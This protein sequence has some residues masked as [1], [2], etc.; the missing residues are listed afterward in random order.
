MA[1]VGA[2]CIGMDEK[3]IAP[4]IL[5]GNDEEIVEAVINGEIPSHALEIQ[6]GNTKRAA[7]IRCGKLFLFLF[8]FFFLFFFFNLFEPLLFIG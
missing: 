1:E 7:I 4:A 8:L 2:G 5:S 6:L 3:L